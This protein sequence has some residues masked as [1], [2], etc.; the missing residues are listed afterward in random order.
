MKKGQTT[1]LLK[2]FYDG[3]TSLE[4][5][6]LLKQEFL[7]T[8]EETPEKDYFEYTNA[9]GNI[10]ENLLDD[11]S[12]FLDEKLKKRR[13][14]TRR[15][16]SMISIAASLIVFFSIFYDIRI[17]KK[18]KMEDNFFLMEQALFQVSETLK[19]ENHEDMVVL[20]I[21]NNVEIIVN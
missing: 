16:Y 17:T 4:E 9:Q 15:I 13:N 7:K 18:Q 10:P 21:D 14:N 6:N 2:K 3:E 19:P 8:D 11:I 20:W 1:E 12:L 5:E